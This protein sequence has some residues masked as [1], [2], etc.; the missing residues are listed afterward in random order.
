MKKKG[1]RKAGKCSKIV[2]DCGDQC[3]F[4]FQCS[5]RHFFNAFSF[6]VCKAQLKGV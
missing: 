5:R 4:T 3:L 2:S 1:G 6:P